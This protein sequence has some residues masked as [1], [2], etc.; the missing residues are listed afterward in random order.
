MIKFLLFILMTVFCFAPTPSFAL[1]ARS[2]ILLP[3]G[4]NL[5]EVRLGGFDAN[6]PSATKIVSLE[7]RTTTY[8]HAYYFGIGENLAAVLLSVPYTKLEQQV[9][10]STTSDNGFGDPSLFFGWGVYN[11]PALSKEA[12]R[13]HNKNGLSSACS[14]LVTLPIGNYDKSEALNIGLNRYSAKGECLVSWKSGNHLFEIIAG[15]THYT[16]NSEYRES[17][18]LEQK[19]LYHL[20]THSSYNVRPTIWL[21]VDTLSQEGGQNILNQAPIN[22]EQRSLAVGGTLGVYLKKTQ[23]LKII[24]LDTVSAS[25]ISPT[26][27]TLVLSYT[28]AW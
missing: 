12:Y 17:N 13:K 27:K 25:N 7:N 20:E 5:S 18:T 11:F 3:S 21:S 22:N 19:P 8:R 2:Y 24:Y 23:L 6:V 26:S 1:D 4:T 28:Y 9:G 16:K 10:T 14:I 15:S